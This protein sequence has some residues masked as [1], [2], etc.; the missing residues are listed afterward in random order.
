MEEQLLNKV[1][2]IAVKEEIAHLIN[3]SFSQNAFKSCLLQRHLKGASGNGLVTLIHETN[4][5]YEQLVLAR[6]MLPVCAL[7]MTFKS[8]PNH[9]LIVD[10]MIS[11][12]FG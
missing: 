5:F 7:I 2:T 3:Y 6:F 11:V 10:I 9:G 12:H 1:K 8:P 4:R